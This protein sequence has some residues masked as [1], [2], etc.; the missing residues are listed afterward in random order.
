MDNAKNKI[1]VVF[2]DIRGYTG[3]TRRIGDGADARRS[4][5]AAHEKETYYFKQRT[6][7]NFYKRL[8]D[9]R[10]FVYELEIG[11]ESATA[12]NVLNEAIGL[13]ARVYHLI[14]ML[15]LGPDGFRIR[16][17]T[18]DGFNEKYE[19]GATDWEGNI[20][21]SCHEFL[22]HAP[23]IALMIDEETKN[24]VDP[25]EFELEN[26]GPFWAVNRRAH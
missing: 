7:A 14:G 12:A 17:M 4:F 16:I 8:G 24:L 1:I 22:A 3:W 13:I 6:K 10:M 20:L 21:N 9:G 11:S 19:D 15:R 18:G 5:V 23:E 25:E 2:T 26:H